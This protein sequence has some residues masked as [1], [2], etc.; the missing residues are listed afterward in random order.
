MAPGLSSGLKIVG[1]LLVL[2]ASIGFVTSRLAPR[3]PSESLGLAKVP[4]PIVA[5][6]RVAYTLSEESGPSP[7]SESR[8]TVFGPLVRI[9]RPDGAYRVIDLKGKKSL[10]VDP[11][12][13]KAQYRDGLVEESSLPPTELDDFFKQSAPATKNS[14]AVRDIDGKPAAGVS[15]TDSGRTGTVWVDVKTSE[16]LLVELGDPKGSARTRL[17]KFAHKLKVDVS[18]MLMS[19]PSGYTVDLFGKGT[20]GP[21]EDSRAPVVRSGIGVGGVTLGM[22]QNDVAALLGKPDRVQYLDRGVARMYYPALGLILVFPPGGGAETLACLGDRAGET[23]FE[24]FPGKTDRG[25]AIGA[26]RADVESAYGEPDF[27]RTRPDP[28][29][30]NGAPAKT[31]AKP[32]RKGLFYQRLGMDFE[33]LDDVVTQFAVHKLPR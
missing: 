19:A 18:S 22:S 31:G 3:D 20:L 10:V 6:S 8:V 4:M 13:K 1:L 25:I 5:D 29:T 15:I 28:P 32:K 2:A 12:R 14:S 21:D 26:K 7:K 9:D 17:S 24:T 27:E 16:P 33:L 30:E 23:G 11:K